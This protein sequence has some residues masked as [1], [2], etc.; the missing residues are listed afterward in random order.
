MT[1]F[2]LADGDHKS[3]PGPCAT[4]TSL[5]LLTAELTQLPLISVPDVLVAQPPAPIQCPM[6]D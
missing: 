3:C 2:C 6:T 4:C 1:Y 5:L